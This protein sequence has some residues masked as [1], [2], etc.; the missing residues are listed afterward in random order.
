LLGLTQHDF[1]GACT[2]LELRDR[3]RAFL[4]PDDLLL[5]WNKSSFDL[6]RELETSAG[7]LTLKAAYRGYHEARARKGALEEI[8]EAERL[9]W[10]R[11]AVLGRAAERLGRAEAVAR[12]LHS[13]G[14]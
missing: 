4:R 2:L 3:W 5:A 11:A 14:V 8:V 6:M 13:C 12:Y 9:A 10:T 1:D 7:H